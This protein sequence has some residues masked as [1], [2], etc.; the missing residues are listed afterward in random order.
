MENIKIIYT[1]DNDYGYDY[2]DTSLVCKDISDLS[3][4]EQKVV[5]AYFKNGSFDKSPADFEQDVRNAADKLRKDS[6]EKVLKALGY[7]P[8]EKVEKQDGIK[9]KDTFIFLGRGNYASNFKPSQ[10]NYDTDEAVKEGKQFFVEVEFPKD[11]PFSIARKKY[12]E[13]AEAKAAKRAESKKLKEIAKA[14]KLL[15]ELG[16]N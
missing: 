15:E 2:R 5:A 3:K 9:I 10:K 6:F 16:A 12:K 1:E 13:E 7:S 4:E 8:T 14:K 11:H